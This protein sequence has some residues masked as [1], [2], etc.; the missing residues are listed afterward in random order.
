MITMGMKFGKLLNNRINKMNKSISIVIPAYNEE[1]R[2]GLSL[3]QITKYMDE[4]KYNYEI[5]IV[6]D[7]STDNTLKIIKNFK[8]DKIKIIKNIVNRGKGYSVKKGILNSKHPFVLFSDADLATPIEELK[9]FME[10]IAKYDIVIASRNLKG[11]YIK[12]KQ[13]FYR[14]FLGKSFPLLVNLIVLNKFE[15][16]Q[17]GFKLFKTNVAKKIVSLQTFDGFS[18]DVE[19]LFIALKLGFKIKEEPVTWINKDGSKV[20]LIGDTFKM[21]FD[22]FKI[23][24]N[25]H[26]GKYGK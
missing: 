1:K 17:C 14:K 26:I 23:R 9:K 2:I 21:F 6:D 7:N 11:S 22:L 13:P 10:L 4:N 8:S 5:I 25:N 19:I 20:K 18:F 12:V 16:T 24:F 15:D 3:I